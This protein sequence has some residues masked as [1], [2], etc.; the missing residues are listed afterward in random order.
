MRTYLQD[1]KHYEDRYDDITIAVCR[2]KEQICI[3]AFHAAKKK[4]KPLAG[5]DKDKD[6]EQELLRAFNLHYY[7]MVEWRAGERW[8][9]REQEIQNMMSEDEAKD[10]QIAEARLTSEPS[11]IHCKK[12]GLRI[13]SKDLMHRGEKYDYDDPKEVLIT[14]E[15]PSCGK[16]SAF[17]QDGTLWERLTTKC[18][19]CNSVMKETSKRKNKTITTTYNCPTCNH[20]YEDAFDL[21]TPKREKEKPDPNYEK[22]KARFC[23]TDEKGKE[24]LDARRNVERLGSIVDDIKEREDNKHIY[25]AV[26][27]IKKPKIAELTGIL[28]PALKK[29]KYTELSFDKPEVGKDVF[30]EFSCLDSMPDRNDRDS[31]KALAK[32]VEAALK[33]TNWR[34][35][36]SG[37]SY[38]LGYL[39]GR[40]RA[41]ERE[42]DIR[43]L[44]IKTRKLSEKKSKSRKKDNEWSMTD[45]DGRKIIF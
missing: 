40:L 12:T 2:Q 27:E 8:E 35:A 43:Q 42:E 26:K 21:R 38:R 44:V 7:F 1:R 45:N 34:L 9:E 23:L 25:D 30:V 3:D 16:R 39:T 19:K 13:I 22:D 37:I 18:P 36:S 17:W 29:A 32:T 24:Y 33:E 4:L 28:S 20:S 10:R 31:R 15:C 11:C 41:Y 14:L 6:P 5:K